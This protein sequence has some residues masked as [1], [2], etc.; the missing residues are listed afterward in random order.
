M[1]FV[2]KNILSVSCLVSA[3]FLSVALTGC[4]SMSGGEERASIALPELN[5]VAVLPTATPVFSSGTLS[6]EKGKNFQGSSPYMD[7]DSGSDM[8]HQLLASSQ[9]GAVS[10]GTLTAEK[11]KSLK[12]GAAYIDSILVEEL[13]GQAQYQLLTE[14]QLD[15]ILSDPWGGAAAAGA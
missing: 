9:A 10:S 14:R 8:Q 7:S 13:G 3:V 15:A 11:Q 1:R 5:C 4:S 6:A 12:D 2:V